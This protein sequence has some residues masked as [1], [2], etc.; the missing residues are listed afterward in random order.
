MDVRPGGR[1]RIASADGG[2]GVAF[3]GEFL[4]VVP[5]ARL[6]RTSAPEMPGVGTGGPPAVETISFDDLGDGR[7][8]MT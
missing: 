1:W 6:V 4:E 2:A 3:S 7:T 5:P 8:R